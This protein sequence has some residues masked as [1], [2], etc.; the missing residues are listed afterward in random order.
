MRSPTIVTCA[1]TG[2]LTTR[3]NHPR[4][5]ITPAEI[6][7]AAVEAESA[8]ASVVH[9]HAR[10][11]VTERGSMSRALFREI[12]ARVRDA[13]S[14]VII[15]LSTGEGGRFVPDVE[16][17]QRAGPGTTLVRPELRVGH[18][19][20]LRPEICTLDLNTMISGAAVVINTPRNVAIMAERIYAAGVLPEIEV[21]NT[22]DLRLARDLLAR[23]VL[24]HPSLFQLVLGVRY[25]A[26]ADP[27][28]LAYLVGQ[29][30]PG[31]TW[32]A[33]GIGRQEFP[34][35]AQAWLLGGHV[36]VGLEDNV[37]IREGV[38]ARNNAELVEK[39]VLLVEQLGGS[40]ATPDE[41]R[42][43]L[44]LRLESGSALTYPSS[45]DAVIEGDGDG[46][47]GGGP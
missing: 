1:V 3:Q 47:A 22:G 8:G 12:V 23:G 2:N 43:L 30:P 45:A 39:A 18:V 32:A 15:N 46:G 6:A 16:E 34:M 33:F 13:G 42:S 28:T 25:G 31:S 11:P 38:L 27:A 35:L 17:P 44:G 10:D 29:L 4:L 40:I 24:R 26:P 37:Y 9:L 21:F 7:C 20:E 5:P 14:R 41:A 36:R 19:E